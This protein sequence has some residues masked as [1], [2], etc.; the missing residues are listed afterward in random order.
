MNKKLLE[1]YA[2]AIC[3]VCMACLTI[4]SGILLYNLA[5]ISFPSAMSSPRIYYPPPPLYDPRIMPNPVKEESP[6]S[7]QERKQLQ[8]EKI[9]SFDE[10]EAKRMHTESIKSIVLAAI[11]IFIASTVFFFHWQIAK[12]ARAR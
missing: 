12:K 4:F 3:F 10:Q 8:L 6:L 11:V 2:L 9:R 7:Q 1:I 5:K